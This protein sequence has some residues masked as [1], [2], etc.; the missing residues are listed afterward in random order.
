V[1]RRLW[2]WTTFIWLLAIVADLGAQAQQASYSS[3]Q[4]K[5]KLGEQPQAQRMSLRLADPVPAQ[6]RSSWPSPSR[7]TS[8]S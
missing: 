6:T 7:S 5:T 8:R 1:Y 4:D 3:A 2:G